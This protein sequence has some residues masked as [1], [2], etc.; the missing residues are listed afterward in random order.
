MKSG[1][2]YK[3]GRTN[4]V[5]RRD[6]EIGIQLPEPVTVIH[7]II[8]DDPEGIEAYWHKH[9]ARPKERR[10]VVRTH[11]KGYRFLQETEIHVIPPNK[12]LNATPE[13]LLKQ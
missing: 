8:T 9:F 13:L 6:F 4:A 5:G 11:F 7:T 12:S 10:K 3:V 1:R 2:Y